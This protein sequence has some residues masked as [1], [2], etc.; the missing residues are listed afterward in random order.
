MKDGGCPLNVFFDVDQTIVS[1][2]GILRPHVREVFGRLGRDG[3]RVYLWSGVGRRT[4]VVRAHDLAECIVECFVKPTFDYEQRWRAAEIG[5]WPDFCVDDHE[6]VV[7]AFGGALVT[8]F[9]GQ[10]DDSEILGVYE[11]IASAGA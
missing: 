11:R 7:E 5:I 3:H 1:D 4:E 6:S 2:K 8:P 9:H 10:P